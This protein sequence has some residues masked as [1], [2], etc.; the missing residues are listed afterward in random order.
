MEHES[1][2]ADDITKKID[3]F[4]HLKKTSDFLDG[5]KAYN[6]QEKADAEKVKEEADDFLQFH[7]DLGEQEEE[8]QNFVEQQF[9]EN[10]IS[11]EKQHF[12]DV[13]ESLENNDADQMFNAKPDEFQNMADEFLS[14]FSASKGL[15]DSQNEKFISSED[16]LTDFKDPHPINE[17]E[18]EP[19]SESEPEIIQQQAAP[20]VIKPPTPIPD[21]P[22]KIVQVETVKKLT[23]NDTQIEAEK[24]FKNI[25]LGKWKF[26]SVFDMHIFILVM[27]QSIIIKLKIETY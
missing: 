14:P 4:S 3:E 27:S 12:D 7:D 8:T 5:E 22:E 18:P 26:Y 25:G 23:S 21:E 2:F 19:E 1:F 15:K 17:P 11:D 6:Q 20:E 9:E 24:I 13:D 16:L 10:I